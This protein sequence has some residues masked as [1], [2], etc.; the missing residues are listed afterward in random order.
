MLVR[1]MRAGK[2]QGKDVMMIRGAGV[3]IPVEGIKSG[4]ACLLFAKATH[5][6]VGIRGG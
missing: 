6:S 2:G 1:S 5:W 4:T 3:L